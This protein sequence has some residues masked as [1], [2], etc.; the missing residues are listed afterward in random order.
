MVS[1]NRLYM[2]RLVCAVAFC[3]TAVRPT[4]AA[5]CEATLEQYD[6]LSIGMPE[7]RVIELVGCNGD[8][9]S[10]MESATATSKTLE[11]QHPGGA[12][13]LTVYLENGRVSMKS[14]YGL[15]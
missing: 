5:D 14:Q 11:W 1:E 2:R 13:Y 8:V 6:K 7:A 10:S 12:S 4:I 9:T 15:K 3:A